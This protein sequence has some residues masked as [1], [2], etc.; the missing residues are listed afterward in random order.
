MK[1][2]NLD[3][4]NIHIFV[5][6]LNEI[7]RKGVTYDNIKSHKKPGLYPLIIRSFSSNSKATDINSTR[8]FKNLLSIKANHNFVFSFLLT[9]QKGNLRIYKNSY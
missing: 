3:G 9:F 1:V 7:F 8:N 5:T 4:E 2:V 6:T